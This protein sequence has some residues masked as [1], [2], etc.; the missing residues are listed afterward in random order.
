MLKVEIGG[1][2][3]STAGTEPSHMITRE[4]GSLD[5]ERAYNRGWEWWLL[6]QAK[7]RNPDIVTMALSWGAPGW[8][9]HNRSGYWPADKD[10]F[11]GDPA[12]YSEDDILFHVRW[13]RGLKKWH[14]ISLDY[15]GIFNER[16]ILRVAGVVDELAWVARL[17]AALDAEPDG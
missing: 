9:G 14:N 13:V 7:K 4:D 16:P 2:T 12:F 1:D 17:R 10:G 5:D 3:Q 8:I 11:V 15:M 6:E